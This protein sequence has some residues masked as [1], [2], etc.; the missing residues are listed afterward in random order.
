LKVSVIESHV[1]VIPKISI[2]FSHFNF[3]PALN[4]SK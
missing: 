1:K 3:L 2:N 4:E